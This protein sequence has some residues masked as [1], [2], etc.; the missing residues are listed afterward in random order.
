MLTGSQVKERAQSRFDRPALEASHRLFQYLY[1][2]GYSIAF[3]TGRS[4]PSR[5]GTVAN[6]EKAG[7][8]KQCPPA[9]AGSPPWITRTKEP[10]YVV[11]HLREPNDSRLASIYKPE[12][13]KT[14]QD[15]GF[16]L[17]G[18]MG[19]QFSDLEGL[20]PAVANWKLPNPMYAI[21]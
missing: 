11:L 6:L 2:S 9:D 20:Y 13:R 21:L 8:G 18:N 4:E 19:D 16:R 14:L 3:I 17:A 7:Y 1:G 12:R 15:A 5:N 10:C